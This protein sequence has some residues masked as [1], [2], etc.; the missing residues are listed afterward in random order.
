VAKQELNLPVHPRTGLTAVGIVNGRPVWPIRGA[1]DLV[2]VPADLTLVSDEA[3]ANYESAATAEFNRLNDD[4]N[5]T[6]ET[7]EYQMRLT[8]DIDRLR[9]E[10]TGRDARAAGLAERERVRLLDQRAALQNRVNGATDDGNDSGTSGGSSGGG[11]INVDQIAE[12]AARGA[13]AALVAAIGQR[14][15]LDSS[16][17]GQ[18]ATAS[19]ADARRHAPVPATTRPR[20]AVTAGVDIPGVARGAEM[21]SINDIVN[22]FQRA[23]KGMPVTRDGSGSERIVCTIRNE[24]EHVV[25]D[26]TSPAQVE[27]LLTIIRRPEKLEALVAGGGWCAPSEI[28]YEFFNV[29]G[30]DGLVD[31][32]TVGISRGG[33]RYPV[34]PSIADAF[35]S[36]GLAPYAVAFSSASDPWLWTETDDI[37]S[38][39]GTTPVKPTI[40][41]A[42]PSFSETRLECYGI[43][44]TAGNLTDDAYP[45]A[46]AHTLR[47]LLTAWQHA[48]NAR[49]ISQMVSLSSAA[50]TGIGSATNHTPVFQTVMNGL[51]LACTDYRAKY[52]IPDETP[53][54]VVAPF[55]VQDLISADLAWR[56]TSTDSLLSVT[57][58]QMR[59]FF[60]D[61]GMAVQFV[62][63][64][65]VRGSGQFGNA[66]TPMTAWP[67]TADFLVYAAGTFIKGNGLTL[68]LGV[69]RDSVLNA[70]ND[71][72]AAWSEECHLVA[73]VGNESRRYTLN[74][75]VDGMTGPVQTLAL[76][77]SI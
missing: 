4:D 75:N 27:E 8:N 76:Q 52:A 56:N 50:I 38:V 45:E 23:A 68:D 42:C 26:R 62:N 34:S 65:Q 29:A 64:W 67:T 10:K 55:W 17:V 20:L 12:A 74:F 19:L 49:I 35:G 71:F 70:T 73:K 33:L 41:V 1:E 31:L 37:A 43:T 61:R 11:N 14:G 36:R 53:V 3:L 51:D 22:A 28:R 58:S 48:Q 69:V 44:L 72:T 15:R 7:L 63:D 9:A 18:R 40:R 13:T 47:L 24:F 39:T 60:S 66:T 5:V 46:T 6:P 77:P 16:T 59:S 25:D 2:T 57:N 54:E 30:V 32:P 21:A